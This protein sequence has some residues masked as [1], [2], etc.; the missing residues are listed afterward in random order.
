MTPVEVVLLVFV[1]A[2]ALA[3]ALLRDVL[4]SIIAF[5]AYSLGVAVVWLLLRAPD[6]GLTEAAVG[7]GV[8]TVLF[9]LTIAKTVRP[10]GDELFVDVN[11]PALGVSGLLVAALATTLTA[12]PPVGSA[13]T[14]VAT[15]RVTNYYL[16]NAYPE[17]GVE[18]A[19]TAVLAAYRGFDTLGEAVV[20]FAALVGL[21]VVLDREVLA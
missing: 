10:P 8:T 19:V 5:A 16:E 7:A 11:L 13:S 4:A 15:S 9:L 3:T 21:L 1:V 2:T 12:L 14:P 18:N 20:V 17:T 6:V